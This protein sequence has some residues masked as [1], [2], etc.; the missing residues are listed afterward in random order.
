MAV[1]R[2]YYFA[3]V[4]IRVSSDIEEFV[5]RICFILLRFYYIFEYIN[6][7]TVIVQAFTRRL[8]RYVRLTD[9][10]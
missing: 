7:Y 4:L 6:E 5:L 8:Q 10:K 9:S 3:R 2:D 1:R